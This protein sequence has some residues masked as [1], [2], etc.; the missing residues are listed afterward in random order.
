MSTESYK[1]FLESMGHHVFNIDGYYWF[2]VAPGIYNNFP[3]HTSIDPL[4][5]KQQNIFKKELS[6]FVLRYGCPVESGKN[7]YRLIINDSAYN[8][9]HLSS[10]ARNQTRRA[11]E[12]CFCKQI[13][14]SILNDKGIALNIDTMQRQGRKLPKN[15][16]KYWSTYYHNASKSEG[17]EAWGCFYQDDLAAYLISFKMENIAHILIVRSNSCYLKFYPNNALLFTYIQ[18]CFKKNIKEI[19]IGYEPLQA[20]LSSL[21]HF[22][23]GMGFK[24]EPVG[25]RIE[26]SPILRP[27][28]AS[29]KSFLKYLPYN[30]LFS[31]VEGLIN[32]YNS[33]PKL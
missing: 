14:F 15:F 11:L 23:I 1:S 12:N 16:Y 28:L 24:M 9:N 19:S 31:K 29:T 20:N 32:F 6:C 7:S 2:N 17:A 8:F 5:I 13:D 21:D 4:I 30:E 33:Q 22:K 27:I 26:I 10:K 18:E 25:Q 3:F